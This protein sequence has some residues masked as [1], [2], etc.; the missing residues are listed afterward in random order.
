MT[1]NTPVPDGGLAPDGPSATDD[2]FPT[3]AATVAVVGCLL[4]AV[5]AVAGS[6]TAAFRG[7]V[8]A[9]AAVGLIFAV[10]HLRGVRAEGPRLP[11]ALVTAVFGFWFMAAPLLYDDVGFVATAGVQFAGLLTAA[12]AGYN[13]LAA[14]EELAGRGR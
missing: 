4:A 9:S 1:A 6:P 3:A 12:F 5:A 14:I 13:A 8:T 10:G 7:S 11:G 2:V